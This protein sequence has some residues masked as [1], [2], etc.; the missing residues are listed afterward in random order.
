MRLTA[1]RLT[2]AA[3]AALCLAPA[4]A[5]AAAPPLQNGGF[6]DNLDHW[7]G[8]DAWIAVTDVFYQ[9]DGSANVLRGDPGAVVLPPYGAQEGTFFAAISA[10]GPFADPDSNIV[11]LSQTF[12][13]TGGRLSGFAAFLSGDY[14]PYLDFGYVKISGMGLSKTLFSS[15]TAAVGAYG[16][17]GWQTFSVDLLAGD[18]TFEAGVTNVGDALQASFLLLDGLSIGSVPEPSTWALMLS[19]FFGLGVMLRR[20][21]PT[22]ARVRARR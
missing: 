7:M 3:I 4:A 8:D 10:D 22:P 12:S 2:C 21:R 20:R 11:T 17:T 18:Y 5:L 1:S 9:R 6:E 15:G 13:T 16:Q 19:G 14:A